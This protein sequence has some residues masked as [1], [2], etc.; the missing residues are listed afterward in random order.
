M[1]WRRW[2]PGDKE[3][4]GGASWSQIPELKGGHSRGAEVYDAGEG[5]PREKRASREEKEPGARADPSKA[6]FQGGKRSE[7][8]RVPPRTDKEEMPRTW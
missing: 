1:V 6:D 2:H 3:G 7:E 5:I 8:T 4:T